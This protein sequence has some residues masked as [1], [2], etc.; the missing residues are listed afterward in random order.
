[1]EMMQE[2]ANE[3]KSLE[4]ELQNILAQAEEAERMA[5]GDPGGVAL[6]ANQAAG[7]AQT[8]DAGTTMFILVD[9]LTL[10][11]PLNISDVF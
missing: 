2:L 3:K 7:F 11:I 9:K 8:A 5:H 1:M 4:S 10:Y 6:G